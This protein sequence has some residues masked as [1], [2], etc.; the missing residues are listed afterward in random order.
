MGTARQ[1]REKGKMQ[2]GGLFSFFRET[3]PVAQLV[4]DL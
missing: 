4:Q 3:L 2:E 1:G